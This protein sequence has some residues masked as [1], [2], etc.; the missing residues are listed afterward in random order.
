[1]LTENEKHDIVEPSLYLILSGMPNL[2]SALVVV[3]EHFKIIAAAISH[4]RKA[5]G[6]ETSINDSIEKDIEIAAKGYLKK[7]ETSP[8]IGMS[9]LL[10]SFY[11]H[12]TESR[13]I[14]LGI[15]NEYVIDNSFVSASDDAINLVSSTLKK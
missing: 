10:N 15:I 14:A 11:F 6:D 12:K 1:M 4:Y 5:V 9:Q 2:E 7:I 3:P 8:S 13:A